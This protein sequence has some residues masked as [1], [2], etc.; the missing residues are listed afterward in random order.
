MRVMAPEGLPRPKGDSGFELL[1]AVHEH[2]V[3]SGGRWPTFDELDRHLW[4]MAIKTEDALAQ[5]PRDL[6]LGYDTEGGHFHN[7]QDEQEISL[8]PAGLANCERGG[9]QLRA[10]LL[11]LEHAVQVERNWEGYPGKPGARPIVTER[12]FGE[13]RDP[14][15]VDHA[16]LFLAAE[17]ARSEPW[18]AGFYRTTAANDPDPWKLGID[19][20]VRPFDGVNGLADYWDRRQKALG[21]NLKL[22]LST[23]LRLAEAALGVDSSWDGVEAD[24]E[25]DL[26]ADEGFTVECWL[27]P[28][29]AEVAES[30]FES[31]HFADAVFAAFKAVEHRV[32]MLSGSTEIG[33]KLMGIALGSAA[34]MLTVTRSSGGSLQ[35]EQSGM[36]D[37]FKGAM[38]ALRNPRG[39]GP[40]QADEFAEAQ[41]MLVLASFLMRRLD[42]AEAAQMAAPAG[43]ATP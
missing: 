2:F 24:D 40:N 5:L 43:P 19:R 20:R 23:S 32:Q 12:S 41:E 16:T 10:M 42:I 6:I 21:R 17:V 33:E 13:G 15:L 29:V 3:L 36:R 31:G 30:R 34:P 22:D 27:H 39:H 25:E 38:Q 4:R 8:T 37:L 7:I 18:T 9:V 28:S 35:S 1:E 14:R 11:L 26:V